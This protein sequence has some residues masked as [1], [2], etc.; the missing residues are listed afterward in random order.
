M[1]GRQ[2]HVLCFDFESYPLSNPP[3]NNLSCAPTIAISRHLVLLL[4]MALHR[5]FPHA[6][7]ELAHDLLTP[8]QDDPAC[9]L[10]AAL[11][12]HL[13]HESETTRALPR[14]PEEHPSKPPPYLLD[15]KDE[16]LLLTPRAMP[17]GTTSFCC[18]KCASSF[19]TEDQLLYL[20]H[21]H[22]CSLMLTGLTLLQRP[23]PREP[24]Q[25]LFSRL[26]RPTRP[27]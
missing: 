6:T 1:R 26:Q 18:A 19:S 16:T 17:L 9:W 24:S 3:Y 2:G 15:M 13:Y 21:S 22:K 4:T 7:Y 14:E 20:L 23:Y 12:N 27:I 10:E 25:L 8:D 5:D 11:S